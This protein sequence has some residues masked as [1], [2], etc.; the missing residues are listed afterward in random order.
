MPTNLDRQPPL[1]LEI[2]PPRA[3]TGQPTVDLLVQTLQKKGK[4]HI[5][6]MLYQT[7]NPDRFMVVI[8]P[9]PWQIISDISTKQCCASLRE[10]LT[11]E[12]ANEIILHN[13]A[14]RNLTACT[15]LACATVL[16]PVIG[17]IGALLIPDSRL[18]I[19]PF[20]LVMG[21]LGV[22]L[23]G[24]ISI[25]LRGEILCWQHRRYRR[26]ADRLVQQFVY[27]TF[28]SLELLVEQ[29]ATT[30]KQPKHP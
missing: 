9:A 29:I 21:S 10:G 3:H 7:K 28:W 12:L 14:G 30:K 8:P 25:L 27:E 24:L 18:P 20:E 16:S 5:A 1:M 19:S 23:I 4:N 6:P 2:S 11:E 22:Q 13:P 15:P 26:Q 17:I